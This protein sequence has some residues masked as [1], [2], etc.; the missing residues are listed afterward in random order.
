[1]EQPANR[2]DRLMKYKPTQ[3]E[4]EKPE[5]FMGKRRRARR[6]RLVEMQPPGDIIPLCD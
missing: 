1:M 6:I 4:K 2:I 3:E 5:N